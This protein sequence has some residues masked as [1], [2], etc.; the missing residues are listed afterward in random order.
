MYAENEQDDPTPEQIKV[1][2]RIVE[3]EYP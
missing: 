3:E 2:R 1:S